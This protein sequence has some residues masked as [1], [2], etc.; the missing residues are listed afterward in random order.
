MSCRYWSCESLENKF[1]EV[2]H[3]LLNLGRC[4]WYEVKPT[5]SIGSIPTACVTILPK[6]PLKETAPSWSSSKRLRMHCQRRGLCHP[7]LLFQN[8]ACHFLAKDW[9]VTKPWGG[10]GRDVEEGGKDGICVHLD[11]VL[12]QSV[13]PNAHLCCCVATC[14]PQGG[15]QTPSDYGNGR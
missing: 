7:P 14:V 1:T 10:V 6:D 3:C 4:F 12:L 5:G 9:P 13:K 11:D 2:S 8:H 15:R